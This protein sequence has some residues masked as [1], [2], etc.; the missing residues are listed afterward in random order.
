M[1]SG[2]FV[3]GQRP[4]LPSRP[5]SCWLCGIIALLLL[6]QKSMLLSLQLEF[7]EETRNMRYFVCS[8]SSR[9]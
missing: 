9:Y 5:Y 7:T 4:L 1:L 2:R 6:L 8:I 3:I